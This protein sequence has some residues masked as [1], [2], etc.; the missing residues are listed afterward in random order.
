MT[1]AARKAAY[2]R[3]VREGVVI[4]HVAVDECALAEA[5]IATGIM[6]PAETVDR[7]LLGIAAASV[8]RQWASHRLRDDE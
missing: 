4:L 6:L 2:R 3:R 5:M 1:E 7:K 8:L